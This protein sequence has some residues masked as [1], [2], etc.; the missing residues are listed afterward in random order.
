MYRGREEMRWST[1]LVHG[2]L[3]DGDCLLGRDRAAAFLRIGRC[4]VRTSCIAAAAAGLC[5]QAFSGSLNHCVLVGLA[6]VA[7]K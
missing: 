4:L 6:Q 3:L 1:S 2:C 5:L 7:A